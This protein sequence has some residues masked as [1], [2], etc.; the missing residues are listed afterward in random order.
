MLSYCVIYFENIIK[1]IQQTE[2]EAL[3]GYECNL[4]LCQSKRD[5]EFVTIKGIKWMI[6]FVSQKRT[7]SLLW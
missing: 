4:D 1:I 5:T 3:S 6:V 2:K 7:K